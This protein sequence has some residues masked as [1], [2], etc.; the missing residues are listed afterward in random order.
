VKVH[1]L[2]HTQGDSSAAAEA[3]GYADLAVR[4][5]RA[6]SVRMIVVG[7]LPGAGKSTVAGLTADRLGAVLLSSDRLRKELSGVAPMT[8]SPEPYREGIYDSEHT[9]R[10]YAELL[11]RAAR[12]LGN[13]ESVV[14]DASWTDERFRS[15]AA[16]TATSVN[17]QLVQFECW[18]PAVVRRARLITRHTGMSDADSQ[19]AD[20]MTIDAAPWPSATRLTSAGSPQECLRQ[21]LSQ[22]EVI[23]SAEFVG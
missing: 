21:V 15:D 17:A 16:R 3:R 5:L 1:C 11:D 22:I 4:H 6:G 12:L 19:I 23:D 7:G 10:T 13:G 2:R 18:A 9:E 20:R 8:R 14:L